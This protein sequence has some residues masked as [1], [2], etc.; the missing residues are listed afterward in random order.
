MVLEINLMHVVQLLYFHIAYKLCYYYLQEKS[1]NK[2]SHLYPI[3]IKTNKFTYLLGEDFTYK[4]IITQW[5]YYPLNWLER[6]MHD[7]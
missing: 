5:F 3:V 4:Y 7:Q 6:S 1:W 2:I